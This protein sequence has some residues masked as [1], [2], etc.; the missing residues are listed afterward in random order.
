MSEKMDGIRGYWDGAVLLSRKGKVIPTPPWFTAG[1]PAHMKLDGE[2]WMGRGTTSE[3]L[4]PLLVAKNRGDK[5]NQV[6]YYIFD[7]PSSDAPYDQRMNL[8]VAELT[9]LPSHIHLVDY[10]KCKSTE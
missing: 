2:L 5:W 10:V 3:Q 9:A 7:L 4:T 8:I 1:L 6:G